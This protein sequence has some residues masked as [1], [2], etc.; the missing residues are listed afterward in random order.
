MIEAIAPE[1]LSEE[2]LHTLSAGYLLPGETPRKMFQRVAKAV[3]VI[4]ED[5]TLY[6]MFNFQGM[7]L[8]AT[9]LPELVS[10]T[11]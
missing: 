8:E 5:E 1:W 7:Q 11:K 4:N 2:G 6:C 3:S 10:V 9:L